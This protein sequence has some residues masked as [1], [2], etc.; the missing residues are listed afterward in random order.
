MSCI[1]YKQDIPV[2]DKYDV[3]VAGSGPSGICAAVAASREGARTA[4]IERY[5]IVGGNLTSGC[6]GPI[7]GQVGPGTMR[8]ELTARLGVR[9]ND[10]LCTTPQDSVCVEPWCALPDAIHNH[11]FMQWIDPFQTCTYRIQMNIGRML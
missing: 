6:V 8:D 7:M 9:G 1:S 10:M 2:L 3:L 11:R 4:I 5:G